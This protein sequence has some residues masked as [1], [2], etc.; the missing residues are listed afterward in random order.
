MK[1]L[2]VASLA[3]FALVWA[4]APNY[5]PHEVGMRWLYTSGEEQVLEEVRSMDGQEV[6]VLSHSYGGI[7]RYTDFL[8]YDD[9]GVWLLAVD[10][11]SGPM[12]YDPP[13][14]LWPKPPLRVGQNWSV[15]TTLKG[16]PLVVVYKVLKVEGVE[17]PAGRFNA[18]V[19]RSSL[20]AQGGGASV[21]DLY[22]VP[23]IGVV[24][25]ATQDGGQI[26]LQKFTP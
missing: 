21:V 2:L 26:D 14:L 7:V 19:V 5:Y 23:G 11:G 20:S 17:V 9:E 18:F 13:I 24:R 15:R 6:W 1:R 25:Y 3:F 4:V 10:T 22:F 8:R 16:T 12:P